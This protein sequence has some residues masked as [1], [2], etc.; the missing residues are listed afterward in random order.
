MRHLMLAHWDSQTVD[1]YDD[2]LSTKLSL[3]LVNN[4]DNYYSYN[5]TMACNDLCM[6]GFYSRKTLMIELKASGIH[7]ATQAELKERLDLLTKLN[8]KGA[9]SFDFGSFYRETDVFETLTLAVSALGITES[10][11]YRGVGEPETFQPVSLQIKKL[12]DKFC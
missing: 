5:T 3:W 9:K 7:S 8:K 4:A 2:T 10:V 6:Y 11:C 1:R 12:A